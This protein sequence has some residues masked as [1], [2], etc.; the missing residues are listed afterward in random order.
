MSLFSSEY[1]CLEWCQPLPRADPAEAPV[2]HRVMLAP[3]AFLGLAGGWKASAMMIATCLC[4]DVGFREKRLQILLDVSGIIHRKMAVC[5][6]LPA[7]VIG[8]LSLSRW[9]WAA[10]PASMDHN[11][12]LRLIFGVWYFWLPK[13]ACLNK[14]CD[15]LKFRFSPG[16]DLAHIHLYS[17]GEKTC[18][19][20][21]FRYYLIS[22]YKAGS[23]SSVLWSCD[24]ST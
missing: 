8:H 23:T 20:G 6:H 14:K 5:W 1:I 12:S 18:M 13:I 22:N 11:N 15:L 7:L 16:L 19:C 21:D 3:N 9:R 24:I 10:L 4:G 2:I 17:L